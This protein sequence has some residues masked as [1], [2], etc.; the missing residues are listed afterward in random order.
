M[1]K[2]NKT[3]FAVV[4]VAA[5]IAAVAIP[6]EA[7]A[8]GGGGGGHT[9]AIGSAGISR[10]GMSHNA[11]FAR[12]SGRHDHDHDRRHRYWGYGFYSD[13]YYVTKPWGV[14]KVCPDY[15]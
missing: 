12:E 13:C 14:V 3:F 6:G 2:S 7:F 8:R 1:S 15:D 11:S 5:A 9:S 4:L 10:G